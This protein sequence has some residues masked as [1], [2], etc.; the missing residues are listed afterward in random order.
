MFLYFQWIGARI[1]Q[2][3]RQRT[4]EPS[5]INGC[6]LRASPDERQQGHLSPRGLCCQIHVDLHAFCRRDSW[7]FLNKSDKYILFFIL[8]QKK[9]KLREKAHEEIYRVFFIM[10]C[11]FA[12]CFL[13][14]DIVHDS[15]VT[16]YYKILENREGDTE[17]CNHT[18]FGMVFHFQNQR[19]H[20]HSHFLFFQWLGN[21]FLFICSSLFIQRSKK[22][23][24]CLFSTF[25]RPFSGCWW[26][27]NPER[28]DAPSPDSVERRCCWLQPLG[29][30]W[31]T[32]S[33]GWRGW[34]RRNG[35]WWRPWCW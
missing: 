6:Q 34:V 23:S 21:P 31:A 10:F 16:F 27:H 29:R 11:I 35:R 25:K 30:R 26:P 17:K 19:R 2:E 15:S 4:Q 12:H 18:F 7:R 9:K 33:C 14:Y 1:G 32:S 13:F 8:K 3:L 22:R 24:T 20:I 5:D 28:I